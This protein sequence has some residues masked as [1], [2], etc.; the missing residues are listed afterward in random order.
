MI[1]PPGDA[2]PEATSRAGLH[3]IGR[4][5]ASL[6]G[7]QAATSVLGAL[8]WLTA[9]RQLS[10]EAVGIGQ[11]AVSL[12]NVLTT[13]GTVGLGTL[14]IA[15]IPHLPQG[16]RRLTVRSALAV[17]G[18]V[19]LV[20]AVVVPVVAIHLLGAENL[21]PVGGSTT[22]LGTFA[23]GTALM[24]VALV[25]DQ[26]VLVLGNGALQL[27]RNLVASATK[28]VALLA[29]A[30]TGHSGGMTIF[31]AWAIGNLVS[32][33]VLS[34]RTRGGWP[35]QQDRRLV[36]PS[37]LRGLGRG[38]AG[39]YSL[40]TVLQVPLMLLPVLVTVLLGARDNGVFG[41]A[42]QVTGFVFALPYAVSLSLFA[43]AE[44]RAGEVVDRMRVTVPFGLAVSLLA[45]AALFPL[46]PW[47]LR[48]FGSEYA[49]QGTPILRLL[50]LAGLPFVI[51]DHYVA[52]R[53][54]QNRTLQATAVLGG[55][56]VLEL[57][58]AVVGARSHG[59]TGL[60][61]GWL[62][63]LAVEAVVLSVPL[64]RAVRAPR[65]DD[66]TSAQTPAAPL[67]PAAAPKSRTVAEALAEQAE[68]AERDETD[69]DPGDD[70]LT[71]VDDPPDEPPT[72]RWARAA[73]AIGV[74]PVVV[75]MA[76]GTV[77][78]SV[79]VSMARE[80]GV[81]TAA[82]ALYVGGLLIVF[83]PAAVGI[84]LPRTPNLARV[85]LAVGLP[86]LLQLSRTVLY[87][88]R[89]MFHD[90]LVHATVLR[91]IGSTDRLFTTNGLLPITAD[92]PGLSVVT[93]AVTD[94]TGLSEHTSAVVVLTVTRLVL[95]LAVVG[96]VERITRSPRA[97]AVAG[98]VYVCNPQFL[99]FNSQYS[100]QT[101]A[102]PLAV[103]T[104]YLFLARRRG[105][106]TS[107]VL[108]LLAAAAT[109]LTHHVTS[110]LLVLVW[111][112]WTL[113]ELV[114]RRRRPNELR[115]LVT[116]AAGTLA[117][118]VAILL[119]PGNTLGSY[120]G[121]IATSSAS[122]LGKLVRGEQ[123]KEVFRNSAGVSTAPWERVA[124]IASLAITVLVLLPALWRARRFVGRRATV[125]V[126][127]CLVAL[128]YP[129]VPGG[130]LTRATSEVGDRSA[131]FVFL[132]IAFV[133]AWWVCRRRLRAWQA[134]L[135]AVAAGVTFIG[136]VVLGVGSFSQQLPGPYQVS[137][138]AR[139]VDPLN[140]EAARW[141]AGNL[142]NGS[143]VYADRVG[144]LLA[145]SDGD[146]FTVRHISTDIDASRLLLD[147][148]YGPEDVRLIRQAGL[149]Y[150]I[151]DRRDANG[152]PNQDVYI[153]NGEFGGG[154]RTRPVPLAALTKLD[155]VD[156]VQRIYDNGAIAIYDVEALRATP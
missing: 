29:L 115:A 51:K 89:F 56:A 123:T 100:Y 1:A 135:G 92:Y 97:G 71:R 22:T 131:G 33:P 106:R 5:V 110:A 58:A 124:I 74:G 120:L 65:G 126:V 93:N 141:M 113:A 80:D 87:P 18:A 42:L 98:L 21:R 119:N 133:V 82:Q 116:M 149:R 50:V 72:S 6:V 48:L 17:A 35:L 155:R 64:V 25:I 142:P 130:H 117:C 55:F 127:L 137:S 125:A 122:D 3:R 60:V 118:F 144:G 90:E 27:E 139:S 30:A 96:M 26:S 156:G 132:G 7:T 101:L 54:V 40:N 66:A 46:A 9:A 12:M 154:D 121:A 86:L 151:V 146:Q 61:T 37:A 85:V 108:P 19:T 114:L 84:L 88:T 13:F 45:N 70:D 43:A 47:V 111:V 107:L 59:T 77:A 52:L 62:L 8:F 73:R 53:R 150:V 83:L 32:L 128:I 140:L 138:D 69:G 67:Q 81:S 112:V 103:L 152:L 31:A 24:A 68:Q 75:L 129:A 105:A 102:L 145:S 2:R 153:E 91:L 76:L 44:G 57:V 147:P 15:R 16:T 10:V 143:R 63:V 109:C 20:L 36:A 14:L 4:I 49:E 136:S 134:V 34:W 78:M 104:V 39:H 28:I 41:P 99:F 94:L 95:A 23:I 148:E 11:A 38:A 79:G